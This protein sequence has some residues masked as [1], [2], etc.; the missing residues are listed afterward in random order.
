[1]TDRDGVERPARREDFFCKPPFQ[2]VLIA[3]EI[4]P[5]TGNIGRLC[6]ATGSTLHLVEPLGFSI[7]EKSLRRAGLDY[8]KHLTVH[9]HPHPDALF[10]PVLDPARCWFLSTRTER[11]FWDIPLQ[12]GDAFV[13]GSESSG[14]PPSL[15]ER[16][17]DRMCHLP[18]LP[19]TVRSLNLANTAAIVLYDA[20]RRIFFKNDLLSSS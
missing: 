6:Y 19:D 3:P 9:L 14:F 12:A 8:W 11:S 18:I 7:D 20:Y 17:E 13:F 16:Y 10:G 4:P 5:N 1:M 2:V 15:H